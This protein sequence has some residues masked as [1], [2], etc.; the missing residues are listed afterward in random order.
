MTNMKGIVVDRYGGPF[1]VA[2]LGIPETRPDEILV[3][4][5]ASSLNPMDW[6]F[7]AGALRERV[8]AVF[9]MVIGSDA[10]GEVA[11]VGESVSRFSTGDQV[12]G[13]FLGYPIGST[14]TFAQFAAIDE[15]ASIGPS[16]KQ[17][18]AAGAA[19]LPTAA[20]AAFDLID[21]VS[22]LQG[23]TVLVVGA[24]GGVGSFAVQLAVAAG[25]VVL[26]ISRPIARERLLS[27]GAVD[28]IDHSA[29]S[30]AE[31][32]RARCVDGVD[33]LLDMTE[34]VEAFSRHL[35]AVGPGGLAA[36]LTRAAT[37]V[38]AEARGIRAID[39]ALKMGPDLLARIA[40]SVDAHEIVLP[41]L[42][43][44]DLDAA[45]RVLERARAG[46]A[47]GKTVVIP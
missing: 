46:H 3:R 39:V 36:S 37:G 29:V 43:R 30:V 27:Y 45:P 16:P 40:S 14:G 42:E 41:P 19:A 23:K 22:P 20:G 47:D 13:Q 10:A 28:V 35:A 15:N 9:P 34:G 44:V 17:V 8:P 24:G 4:I 1:R 18:D 25:A 32:A 21:A 12:H 33:V 5:E 2:E 6:K 7:A 31:A 26:A 11:A 38:N